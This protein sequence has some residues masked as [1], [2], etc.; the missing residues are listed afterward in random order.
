MSMQTYEKA[1]ALM[2]KYPDLQHF[3]GPRDESLIDLAEKLLDLKLPPTYRRFVEE[4]GTGAF[5]SHEFYGIIDDNFIMNTNMDAI[6]ETLRLR[7]Q[8]SLPK[9]LIYIIPSG[10][11]IDDYFL[12]VKLESDSEALVIAYAIGFSEDDQTYEV[13]ANDFGDYLYSK[14][15]L[16]IEWHEEENK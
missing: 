2:Q 15:K 14:V 4:Y 5:G 16:Q 9:N 11:L 6:G 8:Y 10:G 3:I 13:L 7:S 12:W 1:V